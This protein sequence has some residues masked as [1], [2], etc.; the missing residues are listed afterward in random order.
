M[1]AHFQEDERVPDECENCG[2]VDGL[3]LCSRCHSAHFCSRKC[4]KAYWPFHREWCRRNDFAEA[5]EKTQPKFARFLR[6]HGKQAAI[7]DGADAR[8]PHPPSL[9]PRLFRSSDG[10]P[11]PPRLVFS[12]LTTNAFPNPRRVPNE[13]NR[14]EPPRPSAPPPPPDEVDRLERKVATMEDMFGRAN[15]KPAPPTYDADDMRKMAAAETARLER[16]RAADQ[17]SASL[18]A[19]ASRAGAFDAATLAYLTNIPA[20]AE[21]SIPPTL[22]AD[23]GWYK[24]RQN[25]TYVEVFVP[26]PKNA[27]SARRLDVAV[28]TD[29]LRVVA[30]PKGAS[31]PHVLIEGELYAAIKAE[32][33]TWVVVDGVLEI[34]LLKRN[35]RGQYDAGKSNAATFWFSVL[36]GPTDDRDARAGAKKDR[37]R[38]TTLGRERL[39]LDAPPNEYYASEW[40][41]EPEGDGFIGNVAKG[42]GK[43]DRA[44]RRGR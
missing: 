4:Q 37:A 26:L 40:F 27:A 24:W 13:P 9:P 2:A 29:R 10:S 8:P 25:Q 22:G 16:L 21:I 33:S 31:E 15:P 5:V 32:A 36:R 35:R 11:S 7:K 18:A 39:A 30:D 1:A 44:P 43:G 38:G 17:S 3:A 19:S 20:Y 23:H 28:E 34:S 41:A 42:R 14:T 12:N 6:K